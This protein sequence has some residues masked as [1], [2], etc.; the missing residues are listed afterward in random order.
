M[1][2]ACD[3]FRPMIQQALDDAL[4]PGERGRLEA[5]AAACPACAATLAA[6][7]FAVR[8]LA[9]LPAP[10]PGPAFRMAIAAAVARARALRIRRQRQL[11]GAMAGI[12]ALAA[13][14]LVAGW[15]L[16]IG[17]AFGEAAPLAAATANGLL[18]LVRSL[19]NAVLTI[20]GALAPVGGA[21]AKLGWLALASLAFWYALALGLVALVSVAARAARSSAR[22]PLFSL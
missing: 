11:A 15:M 2:D 3:I 13:G 6:G 12:T 10:E 18:P 1:A 22:L 16:A 5:H 19:G 8:A 7:R 20:A 9:A 4:A 17:P 21:A 14:L